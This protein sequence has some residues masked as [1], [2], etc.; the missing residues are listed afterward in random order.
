MHKDKTSKTP[1]GKTCG[2]KAEAFPRQKRIV[3]EKEENPFRPIVQN[4]SPTVQNS[5]T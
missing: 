3:A 2:R 5:K 1:W 4:G